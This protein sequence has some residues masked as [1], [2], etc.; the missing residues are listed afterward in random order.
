MKKQSLFVKVITPKAKHQVKA[1]S[2]THLQYGA[3][4]FIKDLRMWGY[5]IKFNDFEFYIPT[6]MPQLL[7]N[8]AIRNTA[9]ILAELHREQSEG[10][11]HLH[12][13]H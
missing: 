11:K 4:E 7:V 5:K 9:V 6:D 10:F 8:F 3:V 1:G 12:T 2:S 13:L